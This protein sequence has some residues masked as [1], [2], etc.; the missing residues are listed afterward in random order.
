MNIL[1]L[2]LLQVEA[3]SKAEQLM[4]VLMDSGI[5][6]GKRIVTAV[7][8]FLIGRIIIGLLNKLFRKILIR[9][10]VELSI[11]TFLGSMVNILLTVLLIISV[12][13]ALGVETT[14]FA[15][16]LASAGVAIGMALSGNLQNF[17]GG[18]M[19]LLFKPYKV[20]DVIEAQ[21]VS[22]TV[23]EIQIFHTILTTFDN[24]VIYVPN[25]AL[26]SGVITNYSNQATRRVD[27]VFGIEYGEDYERVKSVIERLAARDERILTDPL[28]F[29]A[30]HALADS[31]V[32][33]TLRV[34]VKSE[35]YWG[36]YFDMNQ[37]VYETF[38]SEGISF[39]FPQLTVHQN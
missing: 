21:S 8:V 22:G 29:I 39:P 6:L 19:V 23:K 32:N 36:V 17:A 11:R 16:L 18:L 38:N 30:L 13:G 34:W 9:R 25:G 27:W 3:L 7:I 5:D 33:V 20:G 24:K 14:S 10:N 31:S 4:K 28:P 37:K 2:I 35:D 12:V 15:A 1:S 26:S